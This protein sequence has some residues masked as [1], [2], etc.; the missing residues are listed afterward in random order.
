MNERGWV[1]S[2]VLK[3]WISYANI[4]EHTYQSKSKNEF[5]IDILKPTSFFTGSLVCF[6]NWKQTKVLVKEIDG[7]SFKWV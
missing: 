3:N 5:L 4:Y 2:N 1:F 7:L 6:V